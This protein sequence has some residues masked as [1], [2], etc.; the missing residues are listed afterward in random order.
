MKNKN[1]KIIPV[2]VGLVLSVAAVVLLML[3]PDTKT[4]LS[5]LAFA[6]LAQGIAL[7][8]LVSANKDDDNAK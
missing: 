3:D 8:D 7:L 2:A 5:L 4:I 1:L 6:T